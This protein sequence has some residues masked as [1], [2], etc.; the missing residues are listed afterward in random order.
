[1]LAEREDGKKERRIVNTSKRAL[2]CLEID[3]G[4]IIN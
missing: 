4:Y 2:V 3:M 1:L